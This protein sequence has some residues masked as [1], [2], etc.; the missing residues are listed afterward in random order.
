MPDCQLR[1]RLV[2]RTQLDAGEND[3]RHLGDRSAVPG[4]AAV[5]DAQPGRACAQA[6]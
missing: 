2:E 4:P 5:P 1:R 6:P 3:E